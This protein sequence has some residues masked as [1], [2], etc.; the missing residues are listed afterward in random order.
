MRD[1]EVGLGLA[2]DAGRAFGQRQAGDPEAE[3]VRHG[4]QRAM[5]SSMPSVTDCEELGLMT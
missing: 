1:R 2:F 3:P 4:A 5:A